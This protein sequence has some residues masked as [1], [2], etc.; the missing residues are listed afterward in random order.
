[1]VTADSMALLHSANPYRLT[2]WWRAVHSINS[3]RSNARMLRATWW[4]RPLSAGPSRCCY[5][6]LSDLF[7]VGVKKARIRN[8]MEAGNVTSQSAPT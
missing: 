6:T 2:G 1:M 5:P 7:S 4:E 8:I 3:G